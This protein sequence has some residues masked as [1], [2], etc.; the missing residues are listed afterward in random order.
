MQ[1]TCERVE[2]LVIEAAKTRGTV[3]AFREAMWV[4]WPLAR[5]GAFRVSR[6][7]EIQLRQGA[8]TLEATT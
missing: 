5:F 1:S 8:L 6:C 3:F 7:S 2:Y 4:T